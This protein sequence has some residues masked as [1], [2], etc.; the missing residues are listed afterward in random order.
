M[1]D[2]DLK[3]VAYRTFCYYWQILLPHIIVGKPRSDIRWT[4]QQNSEKIMRMTNKGDNEKTQV[5]L[6]IL[7]EAPQLNTSIT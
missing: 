7:I 2:L 3:P 6:L 1:T 4:C 5:N